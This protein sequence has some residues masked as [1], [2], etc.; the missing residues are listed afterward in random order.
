MLSAINSFLDDSVVLPPGD[1]DSKNLLSLNEIQE[2]RKRR[3]RR[4][5]A[6]L[7]MLDKKEGDKE[8]E[9]KDDDSKEGDDG[10]SDPPEGDDDDDPKKTQKKKQK[11]YPDPLVRTGRPFGGLINDLKRRF[12][13]YLSDLKDGLNMQSLSTAIFIYFAC[14]SGAIAFGGL[15]GEQK[16]WFTK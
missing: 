11:K 10:S 5:M 1:W 8:D 12:P 13:W 6:E 15:Y 14:L 9:D 7:G 3:K 2:I 4:Q 16:L